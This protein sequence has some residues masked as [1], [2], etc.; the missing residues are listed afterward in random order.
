MSD[1]GDSSAENNSA[2]SP[3]IYLYIITETYR[4]MTFVTYVYYDKKLC[5]F[6]SKI[7]HFNEK[8]ILFLRHNIIE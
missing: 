5:R 3:T 4:F 1:C 7:C 2:R 6:K 8:I